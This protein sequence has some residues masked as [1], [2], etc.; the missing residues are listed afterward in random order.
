MN[1]LLDTHT[2][3]WFADKQQSANLPEPTKALL[4]DAANELFLSPASIWEMAIKV[5][6]GK[7]KLTEPVAQ[8][9]EFHLVNN[10]IRLLPVRLSHYAGVE[11]LPLHHRDPFDRLLVCQSMIEKLSIVSIDAAFDQYGVHR[12][13]VM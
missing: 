12:I 5:S 7:L 3:L 1:L 8:L 13:W 6:I 11:T 2:F 9:V 10:S 4:I